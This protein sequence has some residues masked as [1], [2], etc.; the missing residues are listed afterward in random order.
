MIIAIFLAVAIMA[1]TRPFLKAIILKGGITRI[2]IARMIR[3]KFS[4]LQELYFSPEISIIAIP[5]IVGNEFSDKFFEC[6]EVLPV[7]WTL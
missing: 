6:C 7:C 5:N 3:G 1:A 4:T 2:F